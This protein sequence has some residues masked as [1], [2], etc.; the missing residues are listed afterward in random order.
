MTE[1]IIT[2]GVIVGAFLLYLF[3]AFIASTRKH[4]NSSAIFIL[5]LLLGWTFIGWVLSLV[6][7]FTSNTKTAA[8]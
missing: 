5:N 2:F 7:A 3:P 1:G 6:W 8:A 4:N